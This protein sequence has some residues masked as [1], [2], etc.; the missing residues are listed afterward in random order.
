M[1]D[2]DAAISVSSRRR[3]RPWLAPVILVVLCVVLFMPGV[4][5][6]LPGT[7]SWSQDTIAGLRTVSSVKT[8]P[9]HWVGRYPPLHYFILRAAYEPIIRHWKAKGHWRDLPHTG[10]VFIAEPQS[11]IIGSL[12]LAAR[13]VSVLAGIAAVLGIWATTRVLTGDD[14]AALIAG[15]TMS[16][17]A[18][19]V[20]F[21]HL[22]NVDVPATAWFAWSAY[23]YARL[24]TSSTEPRALARAASQ[25]QQVPWHKKLLVL[26]RTSRG[27]SLETEFEYDKT[28]RAKARGSG[29]ESEFKH[30]RYRGGSTCWDAVGLGLFGGLAVA[31]K[32][33]TAGVY[34]GMAVV[35]VIF[36]WM[37][38]RQHDRS[39]GSAI[40]RAV[41]D[42]RWLVGLLAF[43]LPCLY[44]NGAFHDWMG[45]ISRLEY[46]LNPPAQSLHAN[47]LRYSNQWELMQATWRY[48]GG[49][50]GWPMAI[51]M[52]AASVYAI[53]RK[54]QLALAILVPAVSYYVIVIAPIH[55]VYSRF[56]FVPLGLLS[57]LVG[58]LAASLM[59]NRRLPM[60]VKAALFCAVVLP[61]AGYAVAINAE[62][63]TDSR[64][65]VEAWFQKHVEPTANVGAFSMGHEPRLR[66]QYLPRLHE[67]G[68]ATYPV[69]MVRDWFD[70]P[71]PEYLVLTS[72]NFEDFDDSQRSCMADLLAGRLGYEV[73]A[74]FKG[75]YLGTGSSWLSI[76]GWGAPIPGKISPRLIV[77]KKKG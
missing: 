32:D 73:V 36:A 61:T 66:P 57:V 40:I 59:R 37:N 68:Y 13:V 6:G 18:T 74:M 21:A 47:Q 7:V 43:V 77:M 16:I 75:R 65:D 72:Y 41:L 63:L 33:S 24:I 67:L 56:L 25:A 5:W 55:F 3:Q 9:N 39:N 46:W 26:P 50:V 28:A 30:D 31:T 54:P 19:F 10:R 2:M 4:R 23:F 76:A 64:Y 35:L 20:Y 49:A 58:V 53:L 1:A 15:F 12:F 45:Y 34:P 62:M 69:V 14:L 17:G 52:L 11:K 29:E 42:W 70:R 8:W 38:S 27:S 22:G 48:A 51:T 44:I 60:M 71:Q